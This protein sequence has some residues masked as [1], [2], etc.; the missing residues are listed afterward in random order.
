MVVLIS[1]EGIRGM[2]L[3][4]QCMEMRKV[5]YGREMEGRL[6]KVSDRLG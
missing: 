5:N 4:H 3:K 1:G 6:E 2:R